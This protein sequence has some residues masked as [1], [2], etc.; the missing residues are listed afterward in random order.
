MDRGDPP[1]TIEH[2]VIVNVS[3]VNDCTPNFGFTTSSLFTIINEELP[4]G[5]CR[6]GKMLNTN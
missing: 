2:S 3:D 4:K 6:Y 5:R 1:R